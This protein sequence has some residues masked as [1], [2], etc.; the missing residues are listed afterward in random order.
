MLRA[1][2]QPLPVLCLAGPTGS[3]KTELALQ[4]SRRLGCEVINTDSRQVYADFPIICAQPRP[5]ELSQCPHHLYGKLK[6]E[7]KISAGQ[8]CSMAEDCIREVLRRGHVPLLVGGTGMYFHTLL[9]GMAPIPAIDPRLR[10]QLEARV[11]SEGPEKLHA[12]LG[13]IDPDYAIRIHPHDR[14]R[15]VRALEVA[16]QTG[17]TLSWWH[18][19]KSLQSPRAQG[20]LF[21]FQAPMTWLEPRLKRRIDQMLEMGA[22]EEAQKAYTLCADGEAPGWSA[23]GCAELLAFLQGRLSFENCL[24]L[25]YQNT[26]AYAKR[27]NTWFRGRKEAIFFPAEASDQFLSQAEDAWQNL[28]AQSLGNASGG[29]HA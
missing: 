23:I 19:Q 4:L 27:Q 21:V 6:I 24:A 29:R 14:Q 11:E 17:H 18:A 5:E 10:A 1:A 8:W 7:E 12:E 3:G 13:A 2:D 9:H 26:R 20:P 15:I 16:A 28:C 22:L 25:W